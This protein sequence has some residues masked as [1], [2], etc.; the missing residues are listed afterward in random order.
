[1]MVAAYVVQVLLRMREEEARG[2]LEPVLAGAVSRPRWVA[3]QLRTAGSRRG[4]APRWLSPPPWRSPPGLVAGRHA[5]G[6]LRELTRRSAG[7]SC[8]PCWSSPAAVLAVFALLPRRAVAV[9]WLLLG[10]SHPSESG[11]RRQPATAAVGAS[12]SRPSP[13]RRRRH[14]RSASRRSSWC[15]SPPRRS[16][17]PGSPRSGGGISLPDD[18][19]AKTGGGGELQ[20]APAAV[21]NP[22]PTV[23][24]RR[25]RRC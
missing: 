9:S 21:T 11:V 12:T 22:G 6:L 10:A 14:S 7:R 8:P 15:W 16:R 4:R 5:S 1:M 13:I 20:L 3:S 18:H 23:T 24:T 17:R 19:G 25:G 2:R